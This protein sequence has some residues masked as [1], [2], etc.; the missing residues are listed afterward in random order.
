MGSGKTTV[1]RIVA[2]ALGCPFLDLD[3][4]VVSREGRSIEEIFR[5]DGE[6]RFRRAEEEA[7]AFALRKYSQGDLV[8]ALGGGTILSAA[9]RKQ[10]REHAL[11]I[12]LDAPAEVLRG[13]IGTG[14]GRPL[15]DEAFASR[16]TERLPLYEE[17]AEVTIDTSALS[18]QDVAD[19]III[20]CL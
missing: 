3:E 2:D 1:G 4:L 9:S 19:E 20:S 11:C 6:D 16:L 15:A 7:L 12:W 8:L 13:R 17:V 18:P 5:A 10:L 14:S